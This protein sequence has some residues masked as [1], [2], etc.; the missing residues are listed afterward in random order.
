MTRNVGASA[1]TESWYRVWW[2]DATPIPGYLPPDAIPD[3]SSGNGNKMS[4][5]PFGNPITAGEFVHSHIPVNL[6]IKVAIFSKRKRVK[7]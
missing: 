2:V 3:P 1:D 7:K 6:W 4:F 5:G